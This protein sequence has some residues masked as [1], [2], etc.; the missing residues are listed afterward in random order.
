[1]VDRTY[2]DITVIVDHTIN[3]P[4]KLEADSF[5]NNREQIS[6]KIVIFCDIFIRVVSFRQLF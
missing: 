5:S 4:Q 3:A 6:N 1:M 2:F